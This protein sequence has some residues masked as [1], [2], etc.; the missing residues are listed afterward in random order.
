V[1]LRVIAT[2]GANHVDNRAASLENFIN[3]RVIEQAG[4]SD[5][6]GT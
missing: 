5:V 4:P 1:K 3:A 6:S 2:C